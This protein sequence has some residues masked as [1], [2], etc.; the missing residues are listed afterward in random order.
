MD[1]P[2]TTLAVKSQVLGTCPR[3]KPESRLGGTAPLI[4]PTAPQLSRLLFVG[5]LSF[6]VYTPSGTG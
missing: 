4:A 3:V 6:P 5:Y 2:L 1:L